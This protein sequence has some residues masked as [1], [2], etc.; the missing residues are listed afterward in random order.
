MEGECKN[1]LFICDSVFPG[2]STESVANVRCGSEL[3]QFVVSSVF[4]NRYV[5]AIGKFAIIKLLV[6]KR[7][8]HNFF[9]VVRCHD[10]FDT[11]DFKLGKYEC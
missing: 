8:N 3:I 2:C 5:V 10:I 9:L 7:Q 11:I 4:A 1:N 6:W